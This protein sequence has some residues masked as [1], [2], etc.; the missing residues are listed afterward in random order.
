MSE[1]EFK[2]SE[3]TYISFAKIPKPELERL[4]TQYTKWYLLKVI[5]MSNL[6]K[7][8]MF[9]FGSCKKTHIWNEELYCQRCRKSKDE[10]DAI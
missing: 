1:K 2:G 8:F 5:M 9:H 6:K 3:W 4:L 7:F 10:I